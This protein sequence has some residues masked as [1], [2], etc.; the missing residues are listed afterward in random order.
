MTPIGGLTVTGVERSRSSAGT[1]YTGT[2]VNTL[3]STLS[4]PSVAIFPVNRVG[5]P[6]GMATASVTM[7]LPPG[8]TWNFQTPPWTIRASI[9][10]RTRPVP[11]PEEGVAEGRR[12]RPRGSFVV[13]MSMPKRLIPSSLEEALAGLKRDP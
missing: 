5:R 13:T 7:D 12:C 4:D 1:A 10:R 6:L 11:F 8:S 9:R 3:G 2:V